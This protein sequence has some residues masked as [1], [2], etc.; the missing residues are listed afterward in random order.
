MR[1]R[2]VDRPAGLANWKEYFYSGE[3][4]VVSGE[5]ET[6]NEDWILQLRQRGF[7]PI[8]EIA[9]NA[10]AEGNVY[11]T[12]QTEPLGTQV[13]TKAPDDALRLVEESKSAEPQDR[14]TTETVDQDSDPSQ[15]ETLPVESEPDEPTAFFPVEDTP[16]EETEE[17]SDEEQE[18]EEDAAPQKDEAPSLEGLMNDVFERTPPPPKPKRARRKTNKE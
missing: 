14:E 9:E 4:L 11:T 5:T 16:Q 7:R 10:R 8:D 12:G 2:Q 17:A 6:D 15:E 3:L 13:A 1:L 18:P